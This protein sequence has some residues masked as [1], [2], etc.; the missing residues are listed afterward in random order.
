M[1]PSDQTDEIGRLGPS[2]YGI[3]TFCDVWGRMRDSGV[4]W[5]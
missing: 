5:R 2:Q 3:D 4:G 1:A